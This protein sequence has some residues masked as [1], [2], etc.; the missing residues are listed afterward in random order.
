[1]FW[2]SPN[3]SEVCYETRHLEYGAH[4]NDSKNFRTKHW[5][6]KDYCSENFEI[7]T[8]VTMKQDI[9]FLV[10][11]WMIPG[12]L[13]KWIT[14]SYSHRH[15][16]IQRFFNLENQDEMEDHIMTSNLPKFFSELKFVYPKEPLWLICNIVG[17]HQQEFFFNRSA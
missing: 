13:R 15:I 3:H 1:M 10:T 12:F 9:W 4:M 7:F 8:K 16:I 2:E 11:L 17:F 6:E 5:F 14:Y